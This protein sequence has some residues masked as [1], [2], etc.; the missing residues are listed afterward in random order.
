MVAAKPAEDR[1]TWGALPGR[2]FT[3]S[4]LL[5]LVN[6]PC[7]KLGRRIEKKRKN[8]KRDTDPEDEQ[9]VDPRIVNG[10]LTKQGD[11][12]WQVRGGSLSSGTPAGSRQVLLLEGT[13]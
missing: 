13:G 2:P 9:E 4:S 10:T 6:F 7:G 11:S 3:T 8:V 12:P 1:R 5:P